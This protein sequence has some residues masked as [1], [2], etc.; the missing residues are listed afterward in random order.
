MKYK[1]IGYSLVELLIA[2]GVASI[3]SIAIVTAYTGQS[4]VMLKHNLSTLA[5]EDARDTF[6]LIA[7]MLRQSSSRIDI[8]WE[9]SPI[10]NKNGVVTS[11]DT[12][13]IRIQFEL[14]DREAIWPNT[15]ANSDGLY[16]NQYITI[17]WDDGS[18]SIYIRM[19]NNDA[20]SGGTTFVLAESG[21]DTSTVF[22]NIALWPTKPGGFLTADSDADGI[23]DVSPYYD[24]YMSFPEGGYD[25]IVSTSTKMGKDETIANTMVAV[26]GPR[27]WH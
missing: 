27:N 14:P 5:S 21:A 7:M 18:K 20:Y 16:E 1:V 8:D 23:V 4:A 25:L 22:T 15:I 13:A 11:F 10:T 26:V 3:L 19:S 17:E 6:D 24:D 12:E 2:L 9:G